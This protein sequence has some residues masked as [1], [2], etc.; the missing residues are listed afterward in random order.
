MVRF[1]TLPL[2]ALL[3]ALPACGGPP[4]PPAGGWATPREVAQQHAAE[5]RHRRE[6]PLVALAL[7]RSPALPAAIRRAAEAAVPPGA[8]GRAEAVAAEEEMLSVRVGMLTHN[9]EA[10][11]ER[12][13]RDGMAAAA[14]DARAATADVVHPGRGLLRLDAAFAGAGTRAAC[15][16]FYR[17]TGA[18]P[19]F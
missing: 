11:A 9:L 1:A 18:V 13:A 5:A 3:F 2:L 17:R 6:A 7:D 19:G 10:S 16:D 8:S 14:C 12:R 15:L 4:M